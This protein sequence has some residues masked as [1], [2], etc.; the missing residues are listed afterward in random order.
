MNHSVDDESAFMDGLLAGIDSSFFD[1]VPSP[2]PSPK[3][4]RR[5]PS[6]PAASDTTQ[7]VPTR[8]SG[9]AGVSHTNEESALAQ[10]LEGA[11]D[12]DWDDMEEDLNVKKCANIK[13][14]H[15]ACT[16]SPLELIC[17]W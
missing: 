16:H 12:W 13:V 9:N 5:P 6:V 1:A 4:A 14:R 17:I 8:T 15:S 10:L 11:E 3:K 7:T 2:A